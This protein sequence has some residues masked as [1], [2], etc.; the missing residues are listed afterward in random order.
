MELPEYDEEHKLHRLLGAIFLTKV[1]KEEKLMIME[2]EYKITFRMFSKD[3]TPEM[4]SDIIE[5]P[6][7]YTMELHRQYVEMVHENGNYAME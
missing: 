1:P 2:K 4:V 6:M 7:E 5:K 3:Q